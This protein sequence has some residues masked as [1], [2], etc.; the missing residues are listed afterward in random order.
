MECIAAALSVT[1]G[2]DRGAAGVILGARPLAG[3]T[4]SSLVSGDIT[5]EG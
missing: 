4:V 1:A 2:G 3:D 5:G